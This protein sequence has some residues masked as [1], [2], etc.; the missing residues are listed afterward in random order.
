MGWFDDRSNAPGV[1]STTLSS[2]ASVINGVSTEGLS[3]ILEA[4]SAVITGLVIGF[5][6]SW[7]VACVTLG[8]LPFMGISGYMNAKR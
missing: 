5:Y 6:F 7:R 1:L 2:D 4:I 8:V 3:P